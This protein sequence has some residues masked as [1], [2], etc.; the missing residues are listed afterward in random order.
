MLFL[1]EV[2]VGLN[3]FPNPLPLAF[4]VFNAPLLPSPLWSSLW[5]LH[6]K[7]T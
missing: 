4:A 7:K 1:D 6:F 3:I 5:E 2:W